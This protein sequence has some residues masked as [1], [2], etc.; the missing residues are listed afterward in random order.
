MQTHIRIVLLTLVIWG[1]GIC[2]Q[3]QLLDG[4]LERRV[5]VILHA[6]LIHSVIKFYRSSEDILHARAHT[7]TNLV[8][9]HNSLSVSPSLI[10]T[11]NAY[12][13]NTLT[14]TFNTAANIWLG[15][16]CISVSAPKTIFP[17]TLKHQ[18]IILI[19]TCGKLTQK[20]KLC[21]ILSVFIQLYNPL[22]N[23]LCLNQGGGEG[24][25][26]SQL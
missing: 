24:W 2:L 26:L 3:Q 7:H 14:H 20:I 18:P 19:F 5:R 1:R 21:Q 9:L 10:S 6:N 16:R 17:S 11:H 22:I 8:C 25:R 13:L 23:F 15:N 12:T 4:A